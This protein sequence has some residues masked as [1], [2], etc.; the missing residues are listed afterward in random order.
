MSDRDYDNIIYTSYRDDLE[1]TFS[2]RVRSLL[3]NVDESE[4]KDDSEREYLKKYKKTLHELE[5]EQKKLSEIREEIEELSTKETINA[6]MIEVLNET[7]DDIEILITHYERYL[8][9]LQ[10]NPIL[11]NIIERETIYR[12]QRE[13]A[14]KYS[15]ETQKP[16][17]SSIT[18]HIIPPSQNET[19][20]KRV[21]VANNIKEKLFISLGTFGIVLFYIVRVII[22]VLPFVMIGGNFF[23]SLLLITINSFVPY[24]SVVFWIW[25][26]VC[27]INGVQDFWAILYYI[28]FVVIWLPFFINTIMSVFSKE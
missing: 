12:E 24:A 20:K 10:R 11:M 26:L 1:N 22:A 17:V 14:L 6:S 13:L 18:E 2:M 4:L 8:L 16:L 9:K 15:R 21:S 5:R 19:P 28:S 23:L 27:A 25:G 7:A 3:A